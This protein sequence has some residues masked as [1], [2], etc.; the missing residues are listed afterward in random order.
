VRSFLQRHFPKYT[1]RLVSVARTLRRGMTDAEKKLWSFL[2]DNQL[3]V[4]FRRQFPIGK[5]V[6]DFYCHEA[7]LNVEVDGAGHYNDEGIR[8]DEE[9][10]SDL[11]QQ[12]IKVLRYSN[13]EVMEQTE[14]LAD[15]ILEEVRTRIRA[16]GVS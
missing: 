2:R 5:H 3:G 6:L 12:D 10:D 16:K 14:A 11:E 7:K 8:N 4:K 15:D 13:P 9:R 1:R